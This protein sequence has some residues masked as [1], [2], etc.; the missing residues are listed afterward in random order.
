MAQTFNDLFGTNAVDSGATATIHFADF[1]DS[2]NNVLLADPANANPAQKL[3]AFLAWLHRTQLA[4]TDSTGV[5]TVDKTKA[6]EPQESFQPKTFE[7]R[8]DVSQ[9]R[10][11]FNFAVYSTDTSIFDPDDVI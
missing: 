6:I 10:T 5:A 1:V 4:E 2:E 8:E 11:D 3:A 7:V 9:V